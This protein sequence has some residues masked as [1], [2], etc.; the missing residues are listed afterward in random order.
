MTQILTPLVVGYLNNSSYAV[1]HEPFGFQSDVLKAHGLRDALYAPAGFVFDFESLPNLVRGPI[2]ENKR[3]GTAHDICC[4]IGVCPGITKSIAADVYFEIMTYCDS[5]DYNRFTGGHKFLPAGMIRPY[6]KTRD[7]A[8]RWIKA[9][10]VKVWPGSYFQKFKISATAKEIYGMEKDPYFTEE[11][12]DALIEKTEAVSA[13]LKDVNV[14]TTEMVKK[15]DE[16]TEELKEKKF[17][18]GTW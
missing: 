17:D 16:V 15:T 6:I 11:K 5:I 2:G 12:L 4:R 8:R 9:T 10:T 3:G 13:D 18:A 14:D 7:W 1:L